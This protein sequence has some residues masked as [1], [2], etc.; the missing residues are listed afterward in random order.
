VKWGCYASH[1]SDSRS[2]VSN[3]SVKDNQQNR[4]DW[5]AVVVPACSL[6]AIIWMFVL[7]APVSS[8][9]LPLRAALL[10]GLLGPVALLVGT[11]LLR[12]HCRLGN[13]VVATGAALPLPWFFLTESR[14]FANSWISLNASWNDPDSF[15][16]MRYSQ[17]RIISVAL[18]LTTFILAVT[19]LLPS[20]WQ[21]LRNPINRLTWPAF[22]ISFMF[23]AHWFATYA[24]PYRQP[25][26]VDAMQPELG[27]LH[28]EKDGAVFHET[29]V[30]VY[31]DGRYYLTRNDRHLFHYSFSETA[32]EGLLTNDL[33]AELNDILALPELKRTLDRAPT[34]LR[35]R[36]GEGWYTQ[37]GS[38]KITAFTTENATPP[39]S[40]LRTF[41]ADIEREP[42]L[43]TSQRY[44]L[45]DV[46]L[47]FCYDPKAGLGDRAENERCSQ[48]PDG[49]DLC[50]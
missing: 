27:L 41:L 43:N 12:R 50:Y 38:F 26:I 16:Y 14:A 2:S 31:S 15:R 34:A 13:S 22:A 17:L 30:T 4:H 39:P 24:F 33:R 5:I 49:S 46:C 47:G 29:A 1:Q 25:V 18:L 32:Q 23:I 48:R 45:R 37:M 3:C 9:Y 19:R 7:K 42:P 10:A 21:L 44:E 36:H 6:V 40:K 11:L 35:S 20:H 8:D 28:V